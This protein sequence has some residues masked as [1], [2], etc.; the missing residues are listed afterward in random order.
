[1]IRYNNA[2]SNFVSATVG[3]RGNQILV[4]FGISGSQCIIYK[5]SLLE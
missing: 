5:A 1:V 3:M 4:L 2:V